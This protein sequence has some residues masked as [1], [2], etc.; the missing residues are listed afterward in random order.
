MVERWVSTMP[1][2]QCSTIEFEMER[3]SYTYLTLR[4]FRQLEPDTCFSV[5]MGMD[6]LAQLHLW[7]NYEEIVR[8]HAIYVFKREG[9]TFDPLLIPVLQLH[10]EIVVH[11]MDAPLFPYSSTVIRDM[12]QKGENP[13]ELLPEVVWRFIDGHSLY[14]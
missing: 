1:F 6:S 10:P 12:L 13:E 9:Y 14:R 8:H 11:L 2:V 7:R 5:V 4:R 3:P